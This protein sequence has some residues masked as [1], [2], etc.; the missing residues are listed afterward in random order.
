MD[1]TYL[2]RTP[3]GW[4]QHAS[5]LVGL[6]RPLGPPLQLPGAG[7]GGGSPPPRPFNPQPQQ[8]RQSEPSPSPP[9]PPPPP[10]LPSPQVHLQPQQN[11]VNLTP[12]PSAALQPPPNVPPPS[13]YHHKL[14][15]LELPQVP[16]PPQKPSL[17]P[18]LPPSLSPTPPPPPR[19]YHHLGS[20]HH[21]VSHSL[22]SLIDIE[23][24]HSPSRDLFGSSLGFHGL[25][26]VSSTSEHI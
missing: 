14:H 13:L 26:E 24:Q 20:P 16:H 19:K 22:A 23:A 25:S 2:L 21:H 4:N 18:S 3:A 11:D 10:P 15:P 12:F 7:G 17:P 5:H 6:Q 1:S 9:P 8:L